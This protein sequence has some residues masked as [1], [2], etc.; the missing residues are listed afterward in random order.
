[1]SPLF[2][3]RFIVVA[4]KGGVGRTTVSAALALAASRAG[5][6]VLLCQ[7]KAKER[8]S[9]LFGA[10]SIGHAVVQ[11][12]ERLWAVNMTPHAALREYGAMV[13][14]SDF[15]AKQVLENRVTRAFLHAIPGVEDYAMLG[16]AWY[17]TTEEEH[18]RPKYDV[19][20]LDAPATGHVLTLL[21]IPDAILAAVPD[22]PL[23]KS[24][25]ATHQ[26]LRDPRR[27]AFVVVTLAEEL[28]VNEAVELAQ[29]AGA[30][31][32]PL[33]PV[34][35]NAL[36]PPRFRNGGS[37]RGLAML[38][39]DDG[40]ALHEGA[41]ADPALAALVDGARLAESRRALNDRE[42]ERLRREL[43]LPQVHL[44]YLFHPAMGPDAISELSDRLDG[45]LRGLEPI[46]A[47]AVGQR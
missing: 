10:S 29:R 8:L 13:L 33:G 19:V 12:R 35:V 1:M 46:P 20:F 30:L 36:Y 14:R 28:P 32:L 21:G 43:P 47:A 24:A 17:H 37:A 2:A 23:T 31:G 25:R 9:Q 11:I 16:K 22:G 45:Q 42:V 40:R 41:S 5:L 3:R 34:V 15:I 18:G 7:T 26:L 4:G 38:L 6:R 44:P 39:A 27:T